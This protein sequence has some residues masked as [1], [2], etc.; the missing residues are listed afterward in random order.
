MCDKDILQRTNMETNKIEEL[1]V[2][3]MRNDNLLSG[4]GINLFMLSDPAQELLKQFAQIRLLTGLCIERPDQSF[5]DEYLYQRAGSGLEAKLKTLALSSDIETLHTVIRATR[6]KVEQLE[7]FLEESASLTASGD[8]HEKKKTVQ[9]KH[10]DVVKS[11][12][13]AVNNA[14]E[15]I[16]LDEL[17]ANVRLLEEEDNAR[18]NDN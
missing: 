12:Q 16:D 5:L 7:C 10:I 1:Q 2:F 13:R 3:N 6:Q 15:E 11:R 14:V 9:E 4:C 17:T 8:E 18:V